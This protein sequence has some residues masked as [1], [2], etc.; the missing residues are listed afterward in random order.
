MSEHIDVARSLAWVVPA[1]DANNLEANAFRETLVEL[2]YDSGLKHRDI[3]SSLFDDW[4]DLGALISFTSARPS[5]LSVSSEGRITLLDNYHSQVGLSA[6]VL[7][8]SSVS[9]AMA[10]YAN[11]LASPMD[12]DFGSLVG[13]QFAHAAGASLL[14]VAVHVRPAVG[15][16]LKAFQ[17][18]LG[19]L[20]PAALDSAAGAS[21]VDGGTFSGIATQFDNPSTEVVLSASDTASTVSS[22]VTLGSV[23]LRVVGSGV[24]LIEGEVAS[25]VVQ[26]SSGANTEVQYVPIEAGQGYVSLAGS[27]RRVLSGEP[28]SGAR[29][30]APRLQADRARQLQACAPCAARVWGDFNGDC[31][32]LS[33]DVLALSEFVLSRERFEDGRDPIDPLLSYANPGGES[34]DFLRQQANPSQ[35]LMAHAGSDAADPRYAQPAITGL[36]TQHL[37]YATVKKHRFL[38]AMDA[39]CVESSTVGS[40]AQDMHVVVQLSGGDGQNAAPVDADPAFTDVFLEL[41]ISPAPTPFT[42]EVSQGALRRPRSRQQA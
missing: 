22:Q 42:F 36:D 18:Q 10:K 1:V 32:F 20:D 29:Q 17:V 28:L 37:L 41:R 2:T 23:R 14:D 24:S 30:L 31:Q 19:P 25:L 12:V 34:C 13:L 27:R 38:A 39:S 6:S 8:A 21:W 4:I 26:S 33:S 40:G 16:R 35:D 9:A 15:T 7:C 5:A 11:L 3:A